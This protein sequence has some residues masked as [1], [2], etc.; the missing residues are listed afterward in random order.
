MS[1]RA[2]ASFRLRR[3]S[4]QRPPP[5]AGDQRLPH[6]TL[7]SPCPSRDWGQQSRCSGGSWR[8]CLFVC[9]AACAGRDD[10]FCRTNCRFQGLFSGPVKRRKRCDNAR[11]STLISAPR[12]STSV[13]RCEPCIA[14]RSHC[15][16]SC[17]RLWLWGELAPLPRCLPRAAVLC[18]PRSTPFASPAPLLQGVRGP[19]CPVVVSWAPTS[20]PTRAAQTAPPSFLC[21]FLLCAAHAPWLL[22]RGRAEWRGPL[23]A[24]LKRWQTWE[25]L[26]MPGPLSCLLHPRCAAA[27]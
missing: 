7:H 20:D 12:P 18:V 17:W 22:A 13:H 3:A 14:A 8:C 10:A 15:A 24:C 9:A 16:T 11:A 25:W 6:Q 27:C 19:A 23:L 4:R 21:P 5:A 2:R 1:R 26:T